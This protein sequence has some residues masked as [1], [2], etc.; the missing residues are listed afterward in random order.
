MPTLA[1]V[2][3]KLDAE[4]NLKSGIMIRERKLTLGLC[5]LI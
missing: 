3:V 2:E 5:Y 1:Y 4:H